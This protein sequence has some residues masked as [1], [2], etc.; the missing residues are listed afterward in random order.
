MGDLIGKAV[1]GE[2]YY[3]SRDEFVR[4]L[5]SDLNPIVKTIV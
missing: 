2:M 1:V 5:E 3:V 4:I